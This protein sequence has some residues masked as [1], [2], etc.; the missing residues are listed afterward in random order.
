[1]N[2]S[3]TGWLSIPQAIATAKMSRRTL[4]RWMAQ[5]S[6]PFR[7]GPDGHRYIR[8]EQID[9]LRSRNRPS[10][11][12]E[13]KLAE[14]VANLRGQIERLGGQLEDHTELLRNALALYSP[15]TI[16]DLIKKRS[17]TDKDQN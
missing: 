8:Q 10:V 14:E 1:M 16:G 6:L 7:V 5:G 15:K 4:Y 17:A 13:N 2:D 11:S 9:A 3:T 12:S